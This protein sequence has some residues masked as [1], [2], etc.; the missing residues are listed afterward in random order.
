[1]AVLIQPLQFLLFRFAIR[2]LGTG[3]VISFLCLS[4][5]VQDDVGS[6]HLY[7]YSMPQWLE[8]LR[9]TLCFLD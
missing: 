4:L 2:I 7:L 5:L 3:Y 1:M 8:G 6:R 9:G